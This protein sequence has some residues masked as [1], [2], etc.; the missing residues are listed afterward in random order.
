MANRFHQTWQEMFWDAVSQPS[1]DCCWLW[2]GETDKDGYGKRGRRSDANRAFRETGENAAHRI[3]WVLAYGPIPL[4][5]LVRHSCDVPPCVNP[6]H[7]LLGT[8]LENIH[9]KISRGRWN[10]GRRGGIPILSDSEVE[11]IRNL[12]GQLDGKDIAVAYGISGASVSR[13][14]NGKQR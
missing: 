9:D 1:P 4:G 14:I 11:A 5:S 6:S 13:I 7:L 3:S 8:T 2:T 10:G 12:A